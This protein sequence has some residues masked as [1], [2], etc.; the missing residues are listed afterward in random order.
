M[1]AARSF[2]SGR[3]L[4]L[5]R[6][7]HFPVVE[8]CTPLFCGLKTR[9]GLN[10]CP[11]HAGFCAVASS[12]NAQKFFRVDNDLLVTFRRDPNFRQ[13]RACGETV[14]NAISRNQQ[15]AAHRLAS[16]QFSATRQSVANGAAQQKRNTCGAIASAP[17]RQRT[18][19]VAR[20]LCS[21]TFQSASGLHR[22]RSET[23][24]C[25]SLIG[26]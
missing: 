9:A 7:R 8:L 14:T 23:R 2:E 4:A 15:S 13:R 26:G 1:S 22:A 10:L 20:H 18:K 17:E 19:P 24:F 5:L 12:E 11:F 3:A 16:P 21:C 6:R 25:F